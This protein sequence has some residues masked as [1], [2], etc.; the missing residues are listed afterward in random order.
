MIGTRGINLLRKL[1]N[2]QTLLGIMSRL[3]P[4]NWKQWARERPSCIQ[5]DIKEAF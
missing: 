1:L 5:E 4:G 2:E 3:P